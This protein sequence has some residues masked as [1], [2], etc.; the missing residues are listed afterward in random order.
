MRRHSA[1]SYKYLSEIKS[2]PNSIKVGVLQ[3]HERLDGSGY[4][5]GLNAE[6]IHDLSKIIAIADIYDAITS[7]RVYRPRMAHTVALKIIQAETC[8][9]KLDPWI[10]RVFL[11]K[12]TG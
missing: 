11:E 5:L 2:I 8:E 4:P 6:D 9:G 10:G 3:H 1:F 7:D 12:A